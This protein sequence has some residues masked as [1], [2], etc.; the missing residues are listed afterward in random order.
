MFGYR[1]FHNSVS[2]YVSLFGTL[3][4]EIYIERLDPTDN[5]ITRLIKV[6][7]VWGP[8]DKA[9]ARANSDP[10]LNRPWSAILPF[11]SFKLHSFYMMEIDT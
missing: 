6:P 1:F 9:L 7:I 11:M 4:N 8:R 5:S 10:D 2:R 3:F